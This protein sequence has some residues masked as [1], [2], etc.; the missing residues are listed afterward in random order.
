MKNNAD[1]NC[2]FEAVIN[3]INQRKCFNEKM[4]L[5]SYVYRQVWV[6]E[7]EMESKNFPEL[8]AGYTDEEK[9]ENW[10]RLKHSGIYE[11][12]FLVTL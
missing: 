9:S 2:A 8:G 4:N 6:T 12:D 5:E 7:L 11:I 1:G 10:N 3:N